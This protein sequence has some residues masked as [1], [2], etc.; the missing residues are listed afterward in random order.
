MALQLGH[1]PA[2]PIWCFHIGRLAKVLLEYHE[3]LAH[4]CS[5]HSKAAPDSVPAQEERGI[6]FA[7]ARVLRDFSVT[8]VTQ[9]S[10]ESGKP[11]TSLR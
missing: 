8:R 6:F 9:R 4:R 7:W 11:K 1:G 10:I 5:N 3:T 2:S